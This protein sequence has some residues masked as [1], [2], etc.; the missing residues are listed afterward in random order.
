MKYFWR[1]WNMLC[2]WMI[3]GWWILTRM[4][5]SRGI[6]FDTK[7]LVTRFVSMTLHASGAMFSLSE[8]L[9]SLR[10]TCLPQN[11]RILVCNQK[12]RVE[13]P[14]RRILHPISRVNDNH[15]LQVYQF[16]KVFDSGNLNS[17]FSLIIFIDKKAAKIFLNIFS[18]GWN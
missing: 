4:S 8:A 6:N 13:L 11:L 2:I 14:W 10:N 15:D 1:R 5:S 16:L 18:S 12:T 17:T 3:W 9:Y 7:F